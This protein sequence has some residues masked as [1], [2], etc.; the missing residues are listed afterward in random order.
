MIGTPQ[1]DEEIIFDQGEFINLLNKYKL[2]AKVDLLTSIFVLQE[3]PVLDNFLHEIRQALSPTGKAFFL[4]VHPDFGIAMLKKSALVINQNLSYLPNAEWEFAAAYPIV[5]EKSQTFFLPYFHRSKSN[6]L[7]KLEK[8]F[9]ILRIV[10]LK[11]LQRNVAFCQKKNISPFY[12]HPGNIYWPEIIEQPS[13]LL[14]TV[15][16]KEVEE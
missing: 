4:L 13:S 2:L 3:L 8:H 1:K 11:P 9:R 15:R 10:D 7:A 16:K 12:S 14:I 6:Y 5:E